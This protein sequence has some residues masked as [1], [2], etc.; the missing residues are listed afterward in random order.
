MT[1]K[2]ISLE[3]K[4]EELLKVWH[5]INLSYIEKQDMFMVMADNDKYVLPNTWKDIKTA[6]NKT[7]K[8]EFNTNQ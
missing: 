2:R 6:I 8:S 3:Q 7:Y 4:L 1:N 5:N